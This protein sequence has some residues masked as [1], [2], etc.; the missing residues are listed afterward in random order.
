[1]DLIHESYQAH[2]FCDNSDILATPIVLSQLLEALAGFG[3]MPTLGNE[4]N[5]RTAEKKQFI[6]ML[7]TDEKLR[8]EFPNDRIVVASE[9]KTIEE[10]SALLAPI[11][12]R[13]SSG[14][15][16]K[17]G[18]RMSIV[19]TKLYSGN[20]QEYDDLYDK[21]FTYRKVKPFEWDNRIV[22]RENLDGEAINVVST[23]RRCEA[24]IGFINNGSTS[25]IILS[26]VD[27][28]TSP[29][30]IAARFPISDSVRVFDELLQLNTKSREELNRYFDN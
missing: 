8:I 6:I 21:L 15:P 9:G 13:L 30:N 11:M 29:R 12:D 23:I 5:A 3:V 2:F 4:I 22:L 18:I 14:F 19:T 17:S 7:S 1:M 20:S 25:D 26:E 24:S 16:A 28:N 10:F 27:I